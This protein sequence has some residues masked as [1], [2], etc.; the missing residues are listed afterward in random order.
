MVEQ[1]LGDRQTELAVLA[2]KLDIQANL[3]RYTYGCDTRDVE[4]IGS[5]FT[6]DATIDYDSLPPF[7]NGITDF[8]EM[9]TGILS[10]LAST[11]HLLGNLHVEVDGDTAHCTSYVQATHVAE[12]GQM[13]V[14]AGRYDDDLVRTAAGW[15]IAARTFR[16]QWGRDEHGLGRSLN[17]GR[18]DQ[19]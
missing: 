16:R 1:Q 10:Q 9:T 14:G 15:K 8:L 12:N 18:R 2:D 11:Q 4:L 17:V 6:A 3:S 19:P 7:A 5:A 13:F